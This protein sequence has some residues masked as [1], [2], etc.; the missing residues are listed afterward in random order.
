MSFQMNTYQCCSAAQVYPLSV[1]QCHTD[2]MEKRILDEGL[3]GG[4]SNS[5]QT[6]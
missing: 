1:V 6:C 5:L 2:I 4:E 3:E